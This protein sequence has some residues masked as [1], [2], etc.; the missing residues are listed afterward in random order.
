MA[1]CGCIWTL[2]R[3]IFSHLHR[4]PPVLHVVMWPHAARAVLPELSLLGQCRKWADCTLNKYTVLF[5]DTFETEFCWSHQ[6]CNRDCDSFH[7]AAL[8]KKILSKL[9]SKFAWASTEINFVHS[10]RIIIIFWSYF[11]CLHCQTTC[12]VCE[13]PMKASLLRTV[14]RNTPLPYTVN[15][16]LAYIFCFTISR[17]KIYSMI[18]A[19]VY[20]RAI[21]R[22]VVSPSPGLR[23]NIG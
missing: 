1:V 14:D 13:L 12:H 15:I 7:C 6:Y 17:K 9:T 19:G 5:A 3:C 18:K 8:E 2:T 16:L 4:F 10:H 11:T 23:S 21:F 22:C 20:R